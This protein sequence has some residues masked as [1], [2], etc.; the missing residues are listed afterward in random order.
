MDSV[1][2]EIP[3]I[4]RIVLYR[5]ENGNDMP[6]L[7]AGHGEG[8]RLHLTVFPVGAMPFPRLS[9]AYDDREL[10]DSQRGLVEP[11]WRWPERT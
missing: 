6:A 9:V 3:T 2:L 5:D 4:C 11:S 1:I 7:V 8:D 10:K